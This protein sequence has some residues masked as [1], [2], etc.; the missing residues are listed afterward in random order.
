MAFGDPPRPWCG[1]PE[2]FGP[3]GHTT[4]VMATTCKGCVGFTEAELAKYDRWGREGL[5]PGYRTYKPV[6]TSTGY[7]FVEH[8]HG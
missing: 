8:I 3:G 1:N 2:G 7:E 4:Y 5:P 6:R